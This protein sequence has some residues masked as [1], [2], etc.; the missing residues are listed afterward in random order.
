[1]KIISVLL[2]KHYQP[3]TVREIAELAG[4]DRSTVQRN[5]GV[6]V[7]IGIA[8]TADKVAGAQRY[9]INTESEVAKALGKAQTELFSEGETVSRELVRDQDNVERDEPSDDPNEEPIGMSTPSA[10]GSQLVR[11]SW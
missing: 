7:K 8:E 2:R 6:I 9:R 1:M 4:V 10:P 5:I 3:L 11:H